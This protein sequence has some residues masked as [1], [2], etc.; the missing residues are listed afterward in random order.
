MPPAKKTT[1]EL[2]AEIYAEIDRFIKDKTNT[3]GPNFKYTGVEEIA[4]EL[5]QAMG[6]RGLVMTPIAQER[7]CRYGA[8]RNGNEQVHVYLDVTWAIT[9]GT[10]SVIVCST[11]EA[12]DVS[13]KATNKA[14]TAARKYGLIQGF[15]LSMSSEPGRTED[16]DATTPEPSSPA[17]PPSSQETPQGDGG[18]APNP[19]LSKAPERHQWLKDKFGQ[20]VV[21]AYLRKEKL[22]V[23][24]LA[25][26]EVARRV[27][28][29]L[30]AAAGEGE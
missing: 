7:E 22:K 11:G 9:N 20:D 10:D 27:K 26:V 17:P 30:E 13:D 1:V 5:R 4:D 24:D 25:D 16:T 23:Q 15:Q 6:K 18:Q 3:Q 14:M 28:D 12:K 29:A 21:N 2:M 19:D 8:T